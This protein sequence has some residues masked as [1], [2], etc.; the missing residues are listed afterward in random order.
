MLAPLGFDMV[1]AASGT[2][3]LQWLQEGRPDAVLLDISMDDLDGWETARR[4]RRA[5]HALPVVMVSANMFENQPERLREAGCQ[6]FVGKP[7][8]ESEL[9]AVLQRL[10]ELEWVDSAPAL[11]PGPEAGVEPDALRLPGE[12]HAQALHLL[13]LGHVAAL[14]ELFDRVGADHPEFA[15][16]MVQLRGLL[17]R[18]DL[19]GLRRSLHDECDA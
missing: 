4:L 5:G 2:E 11:L 6:A 9:L 7:V 8:I 1:E 10:L 18:Y 19:H 17:Q 12:A 3:C 16:R 13:R 14:R 15:P